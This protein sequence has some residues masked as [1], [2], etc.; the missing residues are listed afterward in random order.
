M[1][2]IFLLFFKLPCVCARVCVTASMV[3]WLIIYVSPFYYF[4]GT[5]TPTF[6]KKLFSGVYN[7]HPTRFVMHFVFSG[8]HKACHYMYYFICYFFSC[9]HFLQFSCQ[10]H[11]IICNFMCLFLFQS[12]SLNFTIYTL[13]VKASLPYWHIMYFCYIIILL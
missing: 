10:S 8:R 5:P 12:A 3:T 4:C 1:Y 7:T 2:A 9:Q 6:Q 13:F 11:C